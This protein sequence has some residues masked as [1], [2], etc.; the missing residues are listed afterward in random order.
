MSNIYYVYAYIREKNKTPYYIGKGKN[1]RRFDYRN[2][3]VKPPRNKK[4]IIICESNL[5]ELGAFALERRLIRWYGRKDLG[6]GILRNQT[7]G[8]DGFTG[9]HR[10]ESKEK[11]R[12]SH[13]K[14]RDQ[15]RQTTIKQWEDGK[16]LIDQDK[17]KEGM[18]KKYGVDNI[19]RLISIC[20]HCGKIGQMVAMRRWHH[21]KCK[22]YVKE[23][24]G[25]DGLEPSYSES[26]SEVLPL[27]DSPK[28]LFA[29]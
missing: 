7:Q 17:I 18:I 20:E 4:L 16:A 27:D 24:D 6:T 8:G 28:N 23:M 10:L 2:R 25:E 12:K 3:F 9:K 29:C 14:I 11:L 26:K 1:N 15:T 19:R 22:F 5:T 13:L 21:N